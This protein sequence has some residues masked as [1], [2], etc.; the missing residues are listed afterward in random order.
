[1]ENKYHYYNDDYSG[2]LYREDSNGI[3]EQLQI[4]GTW[5]LCSL[6][7]SVKVDF[8]KCLDLYIAYKDY[9]GFNAVD[10]V[11]AAMKNTFYNGLLD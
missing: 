3:T 7:K 5:L 11:R 2:Y 8:N 1:M 6:H 4:T 10:E 9:I